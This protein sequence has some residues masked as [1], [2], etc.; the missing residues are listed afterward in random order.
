[1]NGQNISLVVA[2]ANGIAVDGSA[3]ISGP[4]V[5]FLGYA[6]DPQ[7][8]LSSQGD[9]TI[10]GST[11]TSG[12]AIT[13]APGAQLQ[14][15]GQLLVS[16]AGDVNIGASNLVGTNA[17][18]AD[19]LAGAGV[20]TTFTP[21][22]ISIG[23]PINNNANLTFAGGTTGESLMI[24]GA[25]A[26]GNLTV[27]GSLSGAPTEYINN[28]GGSLG[29]NYGGTFTL[30]SGSVLSGANIQIAGAPQNGVVAGNTLLNGVI[31]IT[32][33]N[34]SLSIAGVNG[35]IQGSGG[36]VNFARSG[37]LT[38]QWAA[39]AFNSANYQANN[40]NVLYGGLQVNA[41][42]G[43]GTVNVVLNP[44]IGTPGL[45]GQARKYVDITVNGNMVLTDPFIATQDSSQNGPGQFLVA[46]GTG[47]ITLGNTSSGFA[48]PGFMGVSNITAGSPGTVNA[49]GSITLTGP[50]SNA[51]NYSFHPTGLFTSGGLYLLSN[52]PVRG[53]SATNT[54]TTNTNSG[55]NFYNQGNA[56][57]SYYAN[58]GMTADLFHY[59]QGA[60]GMAIVPLDTPASL[61]TQP[62]PASGS[63]TSPSGTGNLNLPSNFEQ[64][65][66]ANVIYDTSNPNLSASSTLF[67]SV[68]AAVLAGAQKLE[69]SGVL[70][71]N[72][73][74]NY[75]V[76]A[77]TLDAV[78]WY[79]IG[80]T[81][82]QLI[83]IAQD[84]AVAMTSYP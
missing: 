81:T 29:L 51:V 40:G 46:T 43:T 56:G 10:N 50:V 37:N 12:G 36:F 1:L 47:N 5:S 28:T 67:Q 63:S 39:D 31:N 3:V 69:V 32:G 49:N 42:S 16:G 13:I 83:S 26:S 78:T 30:S 33:N 2:N 23:A 74:F 70:P 9:I 62:S 45:S 41:G 68:Y 71:G 66:L 18:N 65:V 84:Q 25:N 17:N 7:Q 59:V 14:N 53:L 58:N 77:I 52:N 54:V 22:S 11:P 20:T 35:V 6:P 24:D 8:Y 21:T 76:Q 34:G 73:T 15:V 75:D 38:L 64:G 48:W 55:V 72:E 44:M 4:S 82:A 79:K 80:S 61:S 57:A 19:F 60:N 27:N